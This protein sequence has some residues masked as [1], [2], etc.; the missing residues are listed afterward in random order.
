[1][2]KM[3]TAT[4]LAVLTALAAVVMPGQ[5]QTL[6]QAPAA[7][8]DAA[9]VRSALAALPPAERQ[10]LLSRP[11]TWTLHAQELLIRRLL[12]QRAER[13]GLASDPQV[14]RR[15]LL[16]R[17]RVLTE[18]YL[19][20][21]EADLAD[22]ARVEAH[23]Q[24]LYRAE[25]QRFQAADRTRA[26]H[27]LIADGPQARQQAMDLLQQLR[28]GADFARLAGEHSIDTGSRDRGGDLGFFDPRQMVPPFREAL[29]GLKTPG[30]LA[31]PVQTQ[32]GWHI[33]RLEERRA[34][35]LAPFDEVREALLA[36]ARQRLQ[37]ERREALQA[38]LLQGA[39]VDEAAA[40][41]AAERERQKTAASR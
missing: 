28:A 5:A 32:F 20:R 13:D 10:R 16:A 11:E 1:M 40:R 26:R 15:L 35:G 37:R 36:E 7:A 38:E 17:E 8:I 3:P 30:E 9:D 33:I 2:K 27:I 24:T 4:A 12:A 41:S 29:E 22:T 31:G 25:P 14:Q 39:S 18:A 21:L 19:E 6:V 23:A 34:A